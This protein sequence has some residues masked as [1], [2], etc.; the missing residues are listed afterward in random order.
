M[1]LSGGE[2]RAVRQAFARAKDRLIEDGLIG[3]G[4]GYVWPWPADRAL[5][6]LPF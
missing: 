4:G 3:E 6:E 1:P 2:D 5:D